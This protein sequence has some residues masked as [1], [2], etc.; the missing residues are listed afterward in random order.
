VLL[1][2]AFD[3]AQLQAALD[4]MHGDA[5]HLQMCVKSVHEFTCTAKAIEF[6]SPSVTGTVAGKVG[7]VA[8]LRVADIG[9]H[10][11]Q[12]SD[13]TLT[14]VLLIYREAKQ[15]LDP[16]AW[17]IVA[18]HTTGLRRARSKVCARSDDP[19]SARLLQGG[20]EGVDVLLQPGVVALERLDLLPG[21]AA[22]AAERDLPIAELGLARPQ[23]I[24]LALLRRLL[25]LGLAEPLALGRELAVQAGERLLQLLLLRLQ[26]GDLGIEPL[27]P[28]AQLGAPLLRGG[29]LGLQLGRLVI[30]RVGRDVVQAAEEARLVGVAA[31]AGEHAEAEPDRAKPQRHHGLDPPVRRPRGSGW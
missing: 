27:R 11:Q 15:R 9:D 5:F 22:A 16:A 26:P 29:S 3:P 28:G 24:D 7:A 19:G 14:N 21:G 31:A 13:L 2:A 12:P 10:V 6:V 8:A 25:D 1:L 23:P 17:V 30:V 4:R 20:E 18:E